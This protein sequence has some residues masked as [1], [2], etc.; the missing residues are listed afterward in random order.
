MGKFIGV[1]Y[2]VILI[3]AWKAS[4]CPLTSDSL[5]KFLTDNAE[6]RVKVLLRD[7]GL[8]QRIK[9]TQS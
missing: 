9:F 6:N 4:L 7:T 1:N 5:N 3:S 2:N 8:T